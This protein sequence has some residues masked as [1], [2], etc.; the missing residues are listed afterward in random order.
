MSEGITGAVWP[1]CW[2]LAAASGVLG[3]TI[4]GLIAQL[5]PCPT[6]IGHL[7]LHPYS[8]L[9]VTGAKNP[10]LLTAVKGI[11]TMRS[12][13]G[14]LL[15]KFTDYTRCCDNNQFITT[16]ECGQNIFCNSPPGRQ[17]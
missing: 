3:G 8:N 1:F 2:G 4:L 16:T 14:V 13:N 10:D 17:T 11:S 6:I 15:Q 7:L 12:P 5:P 9:I